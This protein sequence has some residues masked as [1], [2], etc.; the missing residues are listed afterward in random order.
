MRA[1]LLQQS[2]GV[3]LVSSG[4]GVIVADG[5]SSGPCQSVLA[6]AGL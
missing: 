6:R 5:V 1:L 3:M 4:G 2:L